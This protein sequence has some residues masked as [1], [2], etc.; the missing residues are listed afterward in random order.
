[1]NYDTVQGQLATFLWVSVLHMPLCSL[2]QHSKSKIASFA[3]YISL[4]FCPLEPV[5]SVFNHPASSPTMNEPTRRVRKTI[6]LEE[7]FKI[8]EELGCGSSTSAVA[9]PL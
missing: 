2:H 8:L 9:L 5:I 6:M 3:T 4:H 7:N 1:M